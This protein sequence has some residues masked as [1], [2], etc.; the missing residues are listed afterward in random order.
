MEQDYGRVPDGTGLSQAE[1]ASRLG[2]SGFDPSRLPA[3]Y[4]RLQPQQ[5]RA[6]REEYARR[7]DGKC[8]HC[9][10]SLDTEPPERIRKLRID[11]RRF[12]PNFLR[13]PHH[14]HHAHDTDLT[15]GVVH[16]YCNAVLWQYHGE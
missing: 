16:A 9:K 15:I 12:P 8:Y 11:W 6:V 10:E 13:H 7:Q 2:P 5:R 4:S 14:L 1:P 3:H